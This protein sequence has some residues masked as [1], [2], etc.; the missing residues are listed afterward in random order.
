MASK[1]NPVAIGQTMY[2]TQ[3]TKTGEQ[4]RGKLDK[5][6]IR[7]KR[8]DIFTRLIWLSAVVI[9]GSPS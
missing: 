3:I 7:K 8:A 9:R 4:R 6:L 5:Q 1:L 2:T